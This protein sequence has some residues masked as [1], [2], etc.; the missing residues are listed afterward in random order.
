[1]HHLIC[2]SSDQ[3]LTQTEC[4]I[5]SVSHSV[6]VPQLSDD[7]FRIEFLDNSN[8]VHVKWLGCLPNKCKIFRKE[9]VQMNQIVFVISI[10]FHR[11][12]PIDENIESSQRTAFERFRFTQTNSRVGR[13]LAKVSKFNHILYYCLQLYNYNEEK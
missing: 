1:M 11:S 8:D 7:I 4:R 6:A 9:F 5:L 3:Y 12:G 10:K 13:R 2:T